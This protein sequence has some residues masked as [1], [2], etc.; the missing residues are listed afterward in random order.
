[1][2]LLACAGW[3]GSAWGQEAVADESARAHLERFAGDLTSLHAN[4]EQQVVNS[5]GLVEDRSSGSVWL[6]RPQKFRWQYGGD[7]PELIVADGSHIWMYDEVLEQVTVRDQSQL[8]ANSPLTLLT[9]ISGLDRQF[10]VRD[11]GAVDG[12]NLLELRSNDM[13]SEFERILLGL[14]EH[15]LAT[16]TMEDAFGFRTEISFSEVERN[17]ELDQDLF[18][19]VPP[20]SADL[21]G[22]LPEEYAID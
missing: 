13:E 19:F 16:M 21:I 17:P 1:M 6:H 4:F 10:E 2:M 3:Y 20:E 7:F 5:A 12:L 14:T 8:A 22:E 18:R 11:L 9:D 15:G